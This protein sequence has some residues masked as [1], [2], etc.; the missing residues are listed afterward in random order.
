MCK[1][2]HLE[3]VV[4]RLQRVVEAPEQNPKTQTEVPNSQLDW[5]R[6]FYCILLVKILFRAFTPEIWNLIRKMETAWWYIGRVTNIPTI[7]RFWTRCHR[8]TQ[9]NPLRNE[10]D[11]VSQ[12]I[13]KWCILGYKWNDA[14]W[15]T[16]D[17]FW[18][19]N[20]AFWNT[21]DAFW[22][23]LY[24]F[25]TVFVLPST[26]KCRSPSSLVKE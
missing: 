3:L 22:D 8:T 16:N 14:F 23:T 6:F 24:H 21:N 9:S 11:W 7:M 12:G 26:W 5:M 13:P 1:Y 15:D 4:V 17:A 20:D 10:I 18:D 25:R 2:R 19:S